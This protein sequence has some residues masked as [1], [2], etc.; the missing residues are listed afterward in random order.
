MAVAGQR[1]G[2]GLLTSLRRLGSTLVATLHSRAELLTLELERERIR[3]TRLLV[4][5]V[6]ALFFLALGAFT[7]TI[8]IIVAFWDSQRLVVIGVLTALYLGIGI[9]IAVFLKREADG[10]TRPFS[11]S[12]AQL[13]KDRDKFTGV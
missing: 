4:L 11:S 1:E 10:S 3:V 6:A 12:V 9:G 2:P 7:A 5:G 13:Q 8:F